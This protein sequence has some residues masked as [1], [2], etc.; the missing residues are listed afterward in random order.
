MAVNIFD[1]RAAGVY[2]GGADRPISPRTFQRW[3]Q[4]GCGPKFM[5]IGN[6]IRYAESDLKTWLASRVAQSTSDH[7]EVAS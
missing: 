4:R 7:V 5:R 1:E 3:R 2:L 6:Q